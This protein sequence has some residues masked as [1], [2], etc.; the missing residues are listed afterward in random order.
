MAGAWPPPDDC[1]RRA[2]CAARMLFRMHRSPPAERPA[3]PPQVFPAA[4]GSLAT[5]P[6]AAPTA[7]RPR[8]TA[9]SAA[10]APATCSSAL[11][12]RS[13]RTV[14]GTGRAS[15]MPRALPA[16]ARARPADGATAACIHVVWHA[17]HA[18]A[19]C[20]AR[21]DECGAARSGP[22]TPGP[23][24][25]GA[26]T[27]PRQRRRHPRAAWPRPAARAGPR[28]RRPSLSAA[29]PAWRRP[30]GGRVTCAPQACSPPALRGA[31]APQR[32]ATSEVA[33]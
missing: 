24:R 7:D 5:P 2:R 20:T 19:G 29:R 14:A 10:S 26:R 16:A 9:A 22:Q 18:C 8:R 11:R 3:A 32:A 13:A 21:H 6:S 12:P 1:Y 25:G 28:P 31:R 23:R 15:W 30:A 27:R 33:L 17:A 4:G